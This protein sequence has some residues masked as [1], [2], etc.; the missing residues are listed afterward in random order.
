MYY[1]RTFFCREIKNARY[2][3]GIARITGR[4]F[5]I[6]RPQA[7]RTNDLPLQDANKY[8]GTYRSRP[9]AAEYNKIYI[10]SFSFCIIYKRDNI[11]LYK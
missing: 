6:S 9:F 8:R 7:I 2:Y 5:E 1:W 11:I 4:V 10:M 3:G